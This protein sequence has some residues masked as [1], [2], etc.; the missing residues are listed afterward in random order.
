MA[1]KGAALFS[2]NATTQQK[3]GNNETPTDHIC[4]KNVKRDTERTLLPAWGGFNL[5]LDKGP[6]GPRYLG[7]RK[8]PGSLESPPD[9]RRVR[10]FA[11]SAAW[12]RELLIA[13]LKF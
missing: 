10:Q 1:P 9:Q 13:R 12:A 8:A 6:L 3:A 2:S 4:E 11:L 5:G 7:N